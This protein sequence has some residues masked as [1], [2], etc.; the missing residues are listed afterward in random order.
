MEIRDQSTLHPDFMNHS[1]PVVERA[2]TS[3]IVEIGKVRRVELFGDSHSHNEKSSSQPT[4]FSSDLAL[5]HSQDLVS[6]VCTAFR[7]PEHSGLFRISP[8]I[9]LMRSPWLLNFS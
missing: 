1:E 9:P 5:Q 3:P 4:A 2:S 7:Y 6:R 8:T